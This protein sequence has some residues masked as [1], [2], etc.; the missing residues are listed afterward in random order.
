MPHG[1]KYSTAK[2]RKLCE[3]QQTGYIT[4]H[5]H[6]RTLSK[7]Y[8][9][10]PSEGGEPL[11]ENEWIEWKKIDLKLN[12]QKTKILA[13]DPTTSWQ[14]EGGK[15]EAET[16]FIFLSSKIAAG[17][18]FSYGIKRQLAH[19]KQSYDKPRQ[20]IEKQRHHFVDKDL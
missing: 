5:M 2:Y 16:D 19:W 11:D 13:S 18:D 14:I 20:H 8:K 12:I 1:N 10:R 4:K 9:L 15:V 3:K 6:K 7:S 17:G